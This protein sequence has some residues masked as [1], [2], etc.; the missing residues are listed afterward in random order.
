MRIV[1]LRWLKPLYR[2]DTL[3]EALGMLAMRGNSFTARIVGDGPE[4]ERLE[5]RARELGIRERVDFL[6]TIDANGVVESLLWAHVY[7]STSSTDGASS[8]LFEALATGAFPI[9]TRIPANMASLD[10]K[11]VG[12][13]FA[14]GDAEGLAAQLEVVAK[15]EAKRIAGARQGRAL[16]ERD[17]DLEKNQERIVSFLRRIHGASKASS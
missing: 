14:V 4:R 5:R 12:S 15:D 6:G 1:S 10:G 11:E 2:V 8:S 9:V 16:A 3:I 17:Y 7:V 13:F